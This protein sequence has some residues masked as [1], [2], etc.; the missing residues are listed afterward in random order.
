[1]QIIISFTIYYNG[2]I[3]LRYIC[4]LSVFICQLFKCMC[5]TLSFS[6]N[7]CFFFF[8]FLF[9]PR[10]LWFISSL[11]GSVQFLD[12]LD[13]RLSMRDDSAEIFFQFF[14]SSC[15][16]ALWTALT[17]VGMSTFWCCLS[18]NSSAGHDVTNPPSSKVPWRIVWKGCH[19][20]WLSRT[21]RVSVSWQLP[22]EIPVDPQGSWSFSAP[23]RWSV[24]YTH[25]T[26]PT[27]RTV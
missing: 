26:L 12:Q 2:D 23:S 24:S 3:F 11:F 16:R 4:N 6:P 25:L 18:R 5:S 10:C 7:S 13:R 1:M 27:R 21:I 19:G 8:G 15:R 17:W 9:R 20:A 14:F 22:E